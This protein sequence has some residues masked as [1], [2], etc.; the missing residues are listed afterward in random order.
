[1]TAAVKRQTTKRIND[2]S[3]SWTFLIKAERIF[4]VGY[5]WLL[6]HVVFK[7]TFTQMSDSRT[8]DRSGE[9]LTNL[10]HNEKSVD[11]PIFTKF[12]D[13]SVIK[14][15]EGL[16]RCSEPSQ[17]LKPLLR[18]LSELEPMASNDSLSKRYMRIFSVVALY[19]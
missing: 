12:E 9:D 11:N 3:I 19:W 1:M 14:N 6:Q 16:S 5:K 8:E 15:E 13:L 18:Q 2:S 10:S 4:C 7:S 17:P